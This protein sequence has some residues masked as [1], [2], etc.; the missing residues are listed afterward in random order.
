VGWPKEENM[1]RRPLSRR[2]IR[3]SAIALCA[4]VSMVA[5]GGCPV[6]TPYTSGSTP[7]ITYSAVAPMQV[8][9]GQPITATVMASHPSGVNSIALQVFG[10]G[11]STIEPTDATTCSSGNPSPVYT[12][13]PRTT[14]GLV[15]EITARCTMPTF[16]TN[17]PWLMTIS[18]SASG[19]GAPASVTLPLLVVGGSDD[20]EPPVFT[21]VTGP[22]STIA[23]GESFEMVFR[24]DDT[25]LAIDRTPSLTFWFDANAED[26]FACTNGAPTPLSATEA[27]LTTTCS[28][29][30]TQPAGLYSG[31]LEAFD[32]L[33][34][35]SVIDLSVTVA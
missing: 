17:G 23:P 14:P 29:S 1:V 6:E 19:G 26:A 15:S 10:P 21:A 5:L 34:H 2:V 12:I 18:V 9:A 7:T 16:A 22:P 8:T 28:V 32:L 4:L 33:G 31:S 24:V 35:R 30:A 27:D 20:N 11:H 3:C 25:T 13:V